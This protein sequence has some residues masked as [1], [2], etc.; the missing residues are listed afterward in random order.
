MPAGRPTSMNDNTVKKLEEWFA[1]GL[2]DEECCLYAWISKNTLYNYI[3]KNP[4]FWTRKEILKNSPKIKA[5][6]NIKDKIEIGDIDTSKR[7]LERK[8]KDE[9]STKTEI[10]QTSRNYNSNI[11]LSDEEEETIKGIIETN[12]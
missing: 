5:K 8:A 2:N 3:D 9:F 7:Y 6:M 10:D 11:E 12:L 1:Y 4:H